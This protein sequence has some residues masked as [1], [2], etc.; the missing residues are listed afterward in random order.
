MNNNYKLH[1]MQ[2]INIIKNKAV[3]K[4][5][6]IIILKNNKAYTQNENGIFFNLKKLDDNTLIDIDNIIKEYES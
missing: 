1:L 5:I 6:F 4:S 3:C 2:R